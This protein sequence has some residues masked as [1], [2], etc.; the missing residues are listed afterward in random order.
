MTIKLATL[1][2]CGSLAFAQAPTPAAK[3]KAEI[4]ALLAADAAFTKTHPVAAEA[5]SNEDVARAQKWKPVICGAKA[6]QNC[7]AVLTIVQELEALDADSPAIVAITS[8]AW[9]FVYR[10]RVKLQRL[11]RRASKNLQ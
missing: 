10:D 11:L 7:D 8:Q 6:Q 3:V 4:A 1:F 5:L 9:I 2:L